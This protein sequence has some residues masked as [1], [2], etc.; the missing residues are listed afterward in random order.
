MN[1]INFNA[2]D[3]NFCESTI[4]SFGPHPEYANALTSLF[5]SWIGINGLRN[6]YNSFSTLMLYSSLV[7]NGITSCFYHYY[8]NIGWGLLDRMSMVLIAMSSTYL[9]IQ[10]IHLFLIFDKWIQH[11]AIT[12]IIH[13]L[14]I[15]YFT[16][17]FTV[18]G[19]HWE[20]IFNILFGLF[21]AS[22]PIYMWLVE[23]NQ[24][25]LKMPYQMIKIGWKG[26]RKIFL[27]GI[28]WIITEIFCNKLSI[29][30][31]MFGH[32]WWHI[33]VSYGGYL[34]SLVPVYLHMCSQSNGKQI[35]IKTSN[36]YLPYLDYTYDN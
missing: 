14:I 13:I 7:I 20:N 11:D 33:Y 18:G 1:P 3:H 36:Y 30:K 21:L 27:S 25:N 23:K 26:I 24:W 8:N 19:L 5:I 12:K 16:F 28:F 35:I 4:Y 17:L 22:L 6:P 9:F 32:V 31:Y 15:A 10:H 29:F 34:V 2:Y